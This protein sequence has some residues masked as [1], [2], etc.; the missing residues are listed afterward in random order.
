VS[1]EGLAFAC[2]AEKSGEK[3]K[4]ARRVKDNN[5]SRLTVCVSRWWA[6]VDSLREQKKLEARKM[7][8][9][10]DESHQSAA[11]FVGTLLLWQVTHF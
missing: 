4:R 11:R 3:Q 2:W 10:R 5:L 1:C 7:L 9:S 8:V 6:G